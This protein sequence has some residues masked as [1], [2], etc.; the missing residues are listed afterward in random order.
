MSAQIPP[1]PPH[2]P[3]LPSCPTCKS[4]CRQPY[5]ECHVKD[6]LVCAAFKATWSGRPIGDFDPANFANH[7]KEGCEFCN[8]AGVRCV[9]HSAA[10]WEKKALA[11]EYEIENLAEELEQAKRTA[12]EER[13]LR[14]AAQATAEG[15]REN[16]IKM[17]G[18]AAEHS[19]T[20][21]HLKANSADAQDVATEHGRRALRAETL[22]AAY[23][24]KRDMTCDVAAGEGDTCGECWNCRVCF[25]IGK[26]NR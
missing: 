20:I 19:A 12:K 1:D 21:G 11:A 14:L 7:G 25:A 17:E 15:W 23:A 9:N 3:H 22:L 4:R 24:E 8:K 16:A 6:C 26:D 13:T 2:S 18:L 5:A 10:Y